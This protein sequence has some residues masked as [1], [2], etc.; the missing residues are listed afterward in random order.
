M[1]RGVALRTL[2]VAL[3]LVLAAGCG[4]GGGGAGAGSGSERPSLTTLPTSSDSGEAA[5][6]TTVPSRPTTTEAPT[7]TRPA[8]TT[9][10]P[11]TTT[12]AEPAT[13]AP[14]PIVTAPPRTQPPAT[15]PPATSPP[16]EETTTTEEAATTTTE[17]PSEEALPATEPVATPVDT[18]TQEGDTGWWWLLLLI[19]AVA[20][21]IVFLV[22]RPK[23][24]PIDERWRAQVLQLATDI[25]AVCH[26]L[27]AGS[28]ASGAIAE[29]RWAGVLS[30]SQELRRMAANLTA[31][32]P[33]AELRDAMLAPTDA[34]QSEEL[35]AD[36]ARLNII[37]A[38]DTVRA[39]NERVEAGLLRL[40]QLL[41][42]ATSSSGSAS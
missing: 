39:D 12:T 19:V 15:S 32:A 16:P 11:R 6:S 14:Q 21:L 30:R 42:P 5:G 2:L 35:S 13:T 27:M 7:T 36:A 31:S 28:D 41:N 23:A 9:N 37:G 1:A 34:L 10:P 18:T 3:V 40:R 4:S 17:P 22:T 25:D 38:G 8:P 33:T 24:A 20:G 26:L 29:D